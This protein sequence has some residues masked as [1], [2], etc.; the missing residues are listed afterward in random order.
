MTLQY[1]K[2]TIYGKELLVFVK[3]EHEAYYLTLTG[4]KTLDPIRAEAL[5][6]LTGVKFEEVD[7]PR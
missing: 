7:R 2:K 5:V 4:R 3:K 1:Y 6:K